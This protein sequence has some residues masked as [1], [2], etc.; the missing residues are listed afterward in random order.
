MSTTCPRVTISKSVFC[1]EGAGGFGSYLYLM[2]YDSIYTTGTTTGFSLNTTGTM[3]TGISGLTESGYTSGFAYKYQLKQGKSSYKI[4]NVGAAN[5]IL[6]MKQ[7]LNIVLMG[8]NVDEL[9]LF[10][11]LCA[12]KVIAIVQDRNDRLLLFGKKFGLEADTSSV[13]S[14]V[15]I[16]DMAGLTINLVGYETYPAYIIDQNLVNISSIVVA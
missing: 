12:G 13:D 1:N 11:E 4:E 2:N 6:S 9:K 3:I 14:G 5:G 15:A 10:Y 7:T 16:E 8:T